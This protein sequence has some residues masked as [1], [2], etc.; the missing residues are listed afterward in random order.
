MSRAHGIDDAIAREARGEGALDLGL[1]ETLDRLFAPGRLLRAGYAT[2]R[3]YA[4]ERLGLP[5]RTM[6]DALALGRACRGRPVLRKAVAA[7]LVS[8]CKARA[9]AP[10][11]AGNEPGWTALAMTSTVRELRVAVHAAGEEPPEEF[12]GES[13]RVRMTPVQ[14]DRL[15]QALK[16]ADETLG[17]GSPRWQCYEAIA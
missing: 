4:R 17:G 11:V 3:D 15:D 10:V 5:P 6:Y 2:E 1:G 14:Q 12:E 16:L 7:G 13:L 8:P 9:I